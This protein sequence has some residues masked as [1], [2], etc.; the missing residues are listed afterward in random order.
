M[1]RLLSLVGACALAAA[2]SGVEPWQNDPSAPPT[3]GAT[4]PGD[5]VTSPTP[6]GTSCN[7]NQ[8]PLA[9]PPGGALCS[10][11][12][13]KAGAPLIRGTL[14]LPGKTLDGGQ[15]LVVGDRVACAG[16]DCS[17]HPAFSAAA[18]VD[19]PQ[20]VVSPGL[21]NPHDHLG[22]TRGQPVRATARYDHRHE[23][24]KGLGGKPKV[25]AWQVDFSDGAMAWGE[26]RNLLAGTTSMM[27][28][29][30]V[31]GLLRNLDWDNEGLNHPSVK[32]NTFP[33]G[34]KDGQLLAAQ[35]GYPTLPD[36]A[37]VQKALAWVP[38]VAEGV[39][40]QARNEFSCLSGAQAGAVD[41]TLANT[42]F[43]HAVGI[44]STDA[45]TIADAG[46]RVIWSPRSNV[47][48]YGF[49]A[50]VLLLKHLGVPVALSTDWVV[51]GSM[52]ML[53]ELACAD[54]LNR[55]NYGGAL[56]N[57]QLWQMVT[58]DAALSA[59]LKGT[60]GE[61]AVGQAADVAVFDGRKRA[62]HAAVIRAAVA[63]VALVLRGGSVLY[64]DAPLVQA[65]A[66]G[67]GSGCEALSVCGH[68]RRVCSQ[69]ET[70]KTLAQL[71]A[72]FSG[73][74]YPLFF[75]GAPDNEPSCVPSRPGQYSGVASTA[76][77]DGD[78]LTG[79]KDNCPT[80]FNPPRPMD[81]A[82][83][84]DADGDGLGDACDPKPFSP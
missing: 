62:G 49:T 83:Q 61:L 58:R 36:L 10:A 69:R 51:T 82:S 46:A 25:P 71:K 59:G 26:L 38:H 16:C 78:G 4:A 19:C 80:V 28:E 65:L 22:W 45:K 9:V 50:D 44:T 20:G 47:S 63:D 68:Q 34:D 56:T 1:T 3:T 5:P 35:C 12:P 79:G 24:R 77:P 55:D 70:G 27:G 8:P 6:G 53:R 73:Q 33:L 30:S 43:I 72:G 14:L 84:P 54:R 15:L 48:L 39:N 67:G 66:P 31:K 76:D 23:W 32:N 13:G 42:S 2:C 7:A 52:N 29:G 60:L 81:G 40:A 64:G 74:T 11:T 41:V 21:I 17:S 18:R 75:C 57:E 37:Y